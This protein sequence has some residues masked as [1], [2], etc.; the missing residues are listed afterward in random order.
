MPKFSQTTVHFRNQCIKKVPVSMQAW[1]YWVHQTLE[2]NSVN[3]AEWLIINCHH[4]PINRICQA[5]GWSK[6]YG[7]PLSNTW[8][9]FSCFLL[10]NSSALA[11]A[12][13][14][15]SFW[16]A[17]YCSGC[18]V[19]RCLRRLLVLY[20]FVILLPLETLSSQILQQALLSSA[21]FT[22]K[23]YHIPLVTC[24]AIITENR[25]CTC[26]Q[27]DSRDQAIICNPEYWYLIPHHYLVSVPIPILILV[28]VEHYKWVPTFV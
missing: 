15:T 22:E 3:N 5:L 26:A 11:C 27:S 28:S 8:A 16:R 14:S 10:A 7:F 21:A 18:F 2:T 17:V 25:T 19:I 23:C 9:I 1:F 13:S 12:C 20:D 6:A 4:L 24:L